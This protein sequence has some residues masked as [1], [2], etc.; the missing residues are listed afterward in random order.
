MPTTARRWPRAGT[1]RGGRGTVRIRGAS[2]SSV[3]SVGDKRSSSPLREIKPCRPEARYAR[4]G[5]RNR[6]SRRGYGNSAKIADRNARCAGGRVCRRSTCARVA[7]IS[8]SYWT[9]DGHAV[10]QDMQ[11]RQLSKCSTIE[12]LSGS[13]PT[14]WFIR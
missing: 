2:E 14:P 5:P 6:R 7:S 13:P 8:L 4:S 11:P 3:D 12:S 9:P 10:T 1:R